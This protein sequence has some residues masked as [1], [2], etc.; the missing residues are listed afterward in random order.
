MA[1]QA[2]LHRSKIAKS[3]T[4]AVTSDRRVAACL[5]LIDAHR[6]SPFQSNRVEL[7]SGHAAYGRDS[8][9][10]QGSRSASPA[11]RSCRLLRA[12]PEHAPHVEHRAHMQ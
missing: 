3:L 4:V 8:G 6:L 1:Q 2:E 7:Y 10:W 11:L 12:L 5:H 9:Q